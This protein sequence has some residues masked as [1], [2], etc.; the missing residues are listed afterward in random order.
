MMKNIDPFFIRIRKKD[1]DIPPATEIPAIR[2]P[3]KESQRRLY[4]FIEK[5]LLRKL[6]LRMLIYTL[7]L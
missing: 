5:D 3:M 6:I 2:I 4:D 1:L 7:H